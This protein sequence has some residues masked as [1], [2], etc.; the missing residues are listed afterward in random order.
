MA[1]DILNNIWPEWEI[2]GKPLGRGTYGVVYKAVRRDHNVESHAA[3]KVISIPS[4]SSEVDSLRSEG[5]DINKT[6]TYLQGVVND[7]VSEIQ[8]M[9]SF[10]GVQNIVSVEDYKV[11]EKTDE[12]GWDIYIRMEL[13]TPFNSYVCDKTLTEQE[14]VKLGCDICTALELCAKR[15]V[16]HRDIKP[17][18]IFI[19]QF[20]DFKLGDFGIARKL[21][22]VTGGLSQKG[23]YYYMAPEIEKSTNYDATVDLYSLGLVLYRFLNKN[24]LPFLE[25]EQQV[26]NP[27]E[28][29]AALRRRLDGEQLPVPCDASPAMAEI[30]LCAC[31]PDPRRRFASAAA[32]KNAL[33]SVADGTYSVN[34]AA[35]NK[36]VSVRRAA[37]S[38]EL[39]QTTSVRK[40]P[41]AQQSVGKKINTFGKKKKSKATA[42]IAA[43]LAAVMLIGGGIF[44]VPKFLNHK[45]VDASAHTGETEPTDVYLDTD[46]EQI[47]A[48]IKEADSLAANENYD[49]ALTRLRKALLTYPNSELLKKK[50]NEYTDALASQV[51]EQTLVEAAGLADSVD[52]AA[53]MALIKNAQNTYGEHVDYKEALD[54]YNQAYT[55]QVK[56]DT[57]DKADGLAQQEDYLGAIKAIEQAKLKVGEDRELEDKIKEYE[58]SYASGISA[59]VDIYLADKNI[60]DAKT[61]LQS[62]ARELPDNEIINARLEE[63][64][65]YKVV[66][67]S[68]LD[69]INGGFTWNDGIPGDPFGNTYS[70]VQNYSIFHTTMWKRNF[71]AEYKLNRDYDSLSFVISP[72]SDFEEGRK[73]YVQ[74][75]VDDVLRYTSPVITQKREP[76]KTPSIDIS[77]AEYME[78]IVHV[79]EYACLMLSDVMIESSPMYESNLPDNMTSLSSLNTFNGSIP[80]EEEYPTDTVNNDYS[81]S[82]NY[83]VLHAWGNHRDKR[84]YSAEYYIAKNYGSISMEIAPAACF[85]ESGSAYIKIYADERLVYT[86]KNVAQK[87]TKFKT[88]EIDLT[89]VDYVEVVAVVNGCIII[90]NVV[91]KNIE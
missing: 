57:I 6:R 91:L 32:M 64:N 17:E 59:Q 41:P 81:T 30:I 25:T 5:L 48:T 53:A 76:F 83:A 20:G 77:D 8:L 19:N 24:R 75:Y 39:N 58:D 18:N 62:A 78:I 79:G 21:E 54:T 88:G 73:S 69:P 66:S 86:S 56:A 80:W 11:I 34:E 71:S 85:E 31:S 46:E 51:R 44:A 4:D 23:T 52:Y 42:A 50:E 13:L 40:A 82:M 7:F 2:E 60:N 90:S 12:I 68:T 1:N 15:N 16:I 45:E 74:I 70:D 38:Q 49:E 26:L 89:G 27:T 3:I 33:M 43:A 72:Y 55:A 87:T 10:K 29:M 65:K 14:V 84:T 37:Q 67:L 36:T 9:E 22:N 47:A 61:L 63:V 28:R 35:L